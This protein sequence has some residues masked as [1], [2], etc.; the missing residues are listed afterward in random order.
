MHYNFRNGGIKIKIT[1]ND[2]NFKISKLSE[3]GVAFI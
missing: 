3:F 2:E 1:R